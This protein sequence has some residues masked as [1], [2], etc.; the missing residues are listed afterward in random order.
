ML[1]KNLDLRAGRPAGVAAGGQSARESPSDGSNTP[2]VHPRVG[3]IQSGG[4]FS[5]PAWSRSHNAYASESVTIHYRWIDLF[6]KSLPVVRRMRRQD[7]GCVVCEV[8]KGNA[9]AIPAWMTDQV[10]CAGFS[11]GPPVVSLSALSALRNLLR[12]LRPP[13]ECDKSSGKASPAEL[14][15]ETNNQNVR[16]TDK[17]V[18]GDRSGQRSG[19]SAIR[20]RPWSGTQKGHRRVASKRSAQRRRSP[21]RRSA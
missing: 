16:D 20:R 9:V 3:P 2:A 8:P 12:N 7:G 13:V 15:D 14:S 18:P 6:G 11:E 10:V 5:C 19:S 17:A 21:K 4:P 1:R